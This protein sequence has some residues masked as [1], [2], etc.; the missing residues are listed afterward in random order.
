MEYRELRFHNFLFN[1]LSANLHWAFVVFAWESSAIVPALPFPK[2]LPEEDI[3]AI[4][5]RFHKRRRQCLHLYMRIPGGKSMDEFH[6]CLHFAAS[7]G[8]PVAS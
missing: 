7:S 5:S 6:F 2:S 4:V 1:P 8:L 3:F